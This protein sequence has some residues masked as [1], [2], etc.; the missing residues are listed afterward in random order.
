MSEPTHHLRAQWNTVLQRVDLTVECSAPPGAPCRSVCAECDAECYGI[1]VASNLTEAWEDYPDT[2]LDQWN[3]ETGP[4]GS[5]FV[6]DHPRRDYGECTCVQYM[7]DADW[8]PEAV[9][10]AK[11]TPDFPISDGMPV[12]IKMEDGGEWCHWQPTETSL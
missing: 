10:P 3:Q 9:G 7:A 4:Y 12:S 5:Q 11:D 8:D 6:R 2:P 1:S